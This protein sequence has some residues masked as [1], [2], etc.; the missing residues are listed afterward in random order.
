MDYSPPGSSICEIIL[1]W[2]AISSSRGILL[3][4]R[5]NLRLL[6]WQA[7]SL[8]LCLGSPG[9]NRYRCRAQPGPH[10]RRNTSQEPG[11]PNQRLSFCHLNNLAEKARAKQRL[12]RM[13]SQRNKNKKEKQ[14]IWKEGW[15][16]EQS[17]SSGSTED[18]HREA[19]QGGGR[20]PRR[21]AVSAEGQRIALGSWEHRGGVCEGNNGTSADSGQR[22]NEN[23]LS[24]KSRL[25]LCRSREERPKV[26]SQEA[27]EGLYSQAGK[28]ANTGRRMA[29]KAKVEGR[30]VIRGLR[31]KSEGEWQPQKLGRI[32]LK[33]E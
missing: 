11:S 29:V 27:T 20:G 33:R 30:E 15:R 13:Y 3:T 2:A 9:R 1:E 22:D 23:G 4:Q 6:Q 8:P 16:G 18:R 26:G 28:K 21:W 24:E 32:C 17:I 7:D 5:S 25:S 14:S 31:H 10:R 12:C 19:E